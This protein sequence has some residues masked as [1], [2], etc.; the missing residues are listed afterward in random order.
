MA[1]EKMFNVRMSEEELRRLDEVR[2]REP[3]VPDRATMMRR[4]LER[5]YAGLPEGARQPPET[6]AAE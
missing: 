3:D 1:R 4:L 6:R 2:R 5:A